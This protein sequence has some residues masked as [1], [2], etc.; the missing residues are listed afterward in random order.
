MKISRIFAIEQ[1][2]KEIEANQNP[3]PML[4]VEEFTGKKK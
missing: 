2:I 3:T 1:L 4:S